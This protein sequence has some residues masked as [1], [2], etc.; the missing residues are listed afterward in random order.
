M[1]LS[2]T[3]HLTGHIGGSVSALVDGQLPAEQE[4]RMWSHVHGCAGCRRLVEHEGAMKRRLA[5]LSDPV[6]THA[7]AGLQRALYDVDAW[8]EVDRISRTSRRRRS[9]LAAAGAG[10]VGI[11]VVGLVGLTAPPVGRN[12]VP[13]PS[14]LR[15]DIGVTPAVATTARRS[16]PTDLL[17]W[18]EQTLQFAAR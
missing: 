12:E 4:D 3:G 7:P 6:R 14:T 13:A 8:A 17:G 5:T 11:A 16:T 15:S 1:V 10:T 18:V 2:L 9:A